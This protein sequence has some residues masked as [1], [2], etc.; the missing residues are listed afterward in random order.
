MRCV[1][2][3]VLPVPAPARTQRGPLSVVATVRCSSSRPPRMRSSSVVMRSVLHLAWF[4]QRP[5][6]P[7]FY[8][9][10][11]D[12]DPGRDADGTVDDLAGEFLPREP[13]QVDDL[14]AV[15]HDGGGLG[16]G[17]EPEHERTRERPGLGPRIPCGP[18]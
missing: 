17:G 12:R 9:G 11:G 2:A 3:R 8:E 15:G 16:F 1:M 18:D 14:L 10:A 6:V 4:G 5:T 13:P 7:V